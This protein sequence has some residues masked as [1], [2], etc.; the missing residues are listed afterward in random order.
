MH[1][2][3]TIAEK[4]FYSQCQKTVIH[5]PKKWF[6]TKRNTFPGT[7]S[8]ATAPDTVLDATIT[9]GDPGP[10]AD[11]AAAAGPTSAAAAY[12]ASV[13]AASCYQVLSNMNEGVDDGMD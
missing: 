4:M 13:S 12:A 11:H 3:E 1:G 9:G 6:R 5:P 7:A 8:N 10:N 2:H